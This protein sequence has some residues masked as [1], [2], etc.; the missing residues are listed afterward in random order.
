MKITNE[1]KIAIVAVIGIIAL[2]FG[3]NFLKGISF[4]NN[5]DDY[6]LSFSDISGMSTSSPIFADG[7]KVGT[8]KAIEY[9]YDHRRNTLVKIGVDKQLRIPKG[10]T[11]EI[12]SDLMGN[13]RI[14]LLLANN[15]RERV[16]PGGTIY[17]GKELGAMGK[18]GAMIPQVEKMLPKIDSILSSLNKLM[19]D[20]AIAAS[21]HNVQTVTGNLTVSTR[22]LNTLMAQLN[23]Q[24]PQMTSKANKVL[25]NTQVLTAKLAAVDVA[26]TMSEVDA[27]LNNV[28]EL[29]A[30]L[31][32][33]NGSLGLL[34][35]D[36][37]LYNNL[38]ST[39]KHADSL[40]VNLREH[41]K[42][43]VHFSIF[44]KKDK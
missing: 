26:K 18:M 6:Y 10:S 23:S 19:A 13:V 34:M 1:V 37:S 43:Y 27:T 35:N 5:E 7:Y 25:D 40:V 8:V 3:L 2:F 12:S 44:G 33:N 36:P 14:N 24:L 32:S 28:N 15:P 9:D 41:P 31:N 22:E 16:N 29:T 21:L 39:M 42:R 4:F 11:A 17:G 20:P 38:N 30:K